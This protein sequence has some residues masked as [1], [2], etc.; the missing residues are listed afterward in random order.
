MTA[1]PFESIPPQRII[2]VSPTGSSTG[3][4][5]QSD[6]LKSIQAA[7]NLATPG[8]T[9]M[10]EAGTYTENVKFKASGL[11]DAPIQLISADGPGA[12][13]IVPGAGSPSATISA[14]GEENIVISGFDVSGGG[15]LQNGIQFGQSGSDFTDMTANIVIKDNFVHDTVKDS[16]KV[17]QGD[18]IYVIDNTCTR[19]G[20]Q[21]IDFV[22]VNNSVIARNDVSH[23]TGSAPALFVKGGSTNIL[24][25]QNHVANA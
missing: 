22:A 9:V 24:I 21:G 5:S 23:T 4:G 15:R 20:D 3:S 8:T 25:A 18:N 10:V 19:A 16:I 2:H 11:P 7:V 14:F 17:S 1:L 6:P 13:K 12:A